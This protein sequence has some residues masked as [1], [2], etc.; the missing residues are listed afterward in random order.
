MIDRT[1]ELAD[2]NLRLLHAFN[3]MVLDD[4]SIGERLP[5]G[6][7]VVL[8]PDDDPELA[9]YNLAL[10]LES[11]RRRETVVIIPIAVHNESGGGE[12]PAIVLSAGDTRPA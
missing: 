5:L 10:A 12:E 2:R 1:T 9:D 7:T 8:I 4:P 3:V 11:V 6:A